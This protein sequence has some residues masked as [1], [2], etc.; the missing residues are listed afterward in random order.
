M[1]ID[2]RPLLATLYVPGAP[3]TEL[4]ARQKFSS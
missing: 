3:V 2:A 4:G 1:V